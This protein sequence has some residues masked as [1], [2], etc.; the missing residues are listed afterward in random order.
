MKNLK[1]LIQLLPDDDKQK[2]I[3]S[4]IGES[5]EDFLVNSIM[6]YSVSGVGLV[7][8]GDDDSD[9]IIDVVSAGSSALQKIQSSG[10]EADLNT[11]NYSKCWQNRSRK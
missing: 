3:I 7:A 1:D 4:N 6:D 2:E 11:G 9:E 10:E 8:I 5:P